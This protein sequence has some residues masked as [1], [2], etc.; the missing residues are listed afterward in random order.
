ML[1]RLA[2]DGLRPWM[3]Q[4]EQAAERE[5][6][7]EQ[8]RLAKQVREASCAQLVAQLESD[9][10]Q[11]RTS[12]P[13]RQCASTETARDVKYVRERQALLGRLQMLLQASYKTLC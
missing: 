8:E 9:V 13:D 5:K 1:D 11:L 10:K 2:C 3:S 12:L 7:E 4:L 6:T